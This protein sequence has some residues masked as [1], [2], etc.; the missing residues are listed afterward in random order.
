[1][2]SS[3]VYECEGSDVVAPNTSGS[4]SGNTRALCESIST[5][6]LF[7]NRLMCMGRLLRDSWKQYMAPAEIGSLSEETGR[8][9]SI[10]QI[11][12]HLEGKKF[13]IRN[14]MNITNLNFFAELLT[15][16]LHKGSRHRFHVRVSTAKGDPPASDRVFVLVRI[17]SRVHY[18]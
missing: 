1:M 5:W 8:T 12:I 3:K 18:A 15:F 16:D 11:G 6:T 9:Q 13:L 7:S 17:N 14:L 10:L 4:S 2:T